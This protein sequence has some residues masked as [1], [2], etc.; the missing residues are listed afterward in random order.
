MLIL[1]INYFFIGN[2]SCSI[3]ATVKC[4]RPLSDMQLHWI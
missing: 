3:F 2:D 4:N 1:L